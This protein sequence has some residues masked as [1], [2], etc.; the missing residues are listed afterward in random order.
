VKKTS[1]SKVQNIPPRGPRKAQPYIESPERWMTF[2]FGG[3]K[4]KIL[5]ELKLKNAGYEILERRNI[6]GNTPRHPNPVSQLDL[7]KQISLHCGWH[8]PRA[9][10]TS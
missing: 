1:E 6:F 9:F 8:C 2:T 10:K 4:G 7:R 5:C 3:F